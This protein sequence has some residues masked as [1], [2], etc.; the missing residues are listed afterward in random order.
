MKEF[1]PCTPRVRCK[2]TFIATGMGGACLE[3]PI[4]KV[5]D[6]KKRRERPKLRWTDAVKIN[7]EKH[8]VRRELR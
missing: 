8:I 2:V 7:L 6:G 5:T 1:I 3:V 4:E